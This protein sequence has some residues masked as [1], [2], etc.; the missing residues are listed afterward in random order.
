MIRD[1]RRLNLFL[2]YDL[3]SKAFELKLFFSGGVK[4]THNTRHVT[5]SMMSG[6]SSMGMSSSDSM[7]GIGGDIGGFTGDRGCGERCGA[8]DLAGAAGADGFN[9]PSPYHDPKPQQWPVKL[10]SLQSEG[11]GDG[12]AGLCDLVSMAFYGYLGE[13]YTDITEGF[14]G[15]LFR[16]FPGW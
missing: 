5:M 12:H 8:G 6:E 7:E 13:L 11:R 9:V 3:T 10:G 15:F 4:K 16:I 14:T 2:D 1:S